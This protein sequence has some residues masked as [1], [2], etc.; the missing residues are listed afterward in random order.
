MHNILHIRVHQHSF[1]MKYKK[2][3]FG[4]FVDWLCDSMSDNLK[5]DLGEE[6]K[7]KVAC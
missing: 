3:H 5:P 7:Q 6:G 2:N 4:M 1:K